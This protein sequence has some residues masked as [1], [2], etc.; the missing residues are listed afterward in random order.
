MAHNN[1]FPATKCNSPFRYPGGKYY[2][3]AQIINHMPAHDKYGEPFCGGGSIF[4][5]KENATVSV[6]NDKD[7]ELMNCYRWIQ[8]DVESLIASL[9][10][11]EATKELHTFMKQYEPSNDLERATR[12]YYLNRTSY[13]GIMRI[14]NCYWSYND[15]HSMR[16]ENWP[17][18]LRLVSSKLQGAKLLCADFEDIINHVDDGSFLFV[19][20]PYVNADQHKFYTCR[21]DMAS[22]E[23]L[24]RVLRANSHRLRFLLTYDNSPEVRALYGWC[25][26]TEEVE[27]GYNIGRT[28]DQR[29]KRMLRDGFKGRRSRGRE[30]FI[31]NYD[32]P[33]DPCARAGM[34]LSA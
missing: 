31:M 33:G 3:R 14:E 18:H 24:E 27:W 29:N 2:A 1:T 21:F 30:L 25:P 28:D 34:R 16:P 20:P 23:R 11:M 15:K 22:H 4:F 7:E 26:N 32:P 8:N 17:R 6:L 12:W 5:A 9:E 19:D 13:S 10:G